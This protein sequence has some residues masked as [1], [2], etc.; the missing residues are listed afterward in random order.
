MKCLGPSLPYVD[1]TMKEQV[2]SLSLSIFYPYRDFFENDRFSSLEMFFLKRLVW[3]VSSKIIN[4]Y[5]ASLIVESMYT[6]RT[7]RSR[8]KQTQ[9]QTQMKDLESKQQ[10]NI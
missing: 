3:P 5:N 10:K 4:N 7:G 6:V 9:T 1:S 2:S 8:H